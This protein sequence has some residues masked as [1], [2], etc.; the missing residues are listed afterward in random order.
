MAFGFQRERGATARGYVNVSNENFPV[1]FR[2]SRR[3]YDKFVEHQ[4]ARKRRPRIFDLTDALAQTQRQLRDVEKEL[5]ELRRRLSLESRAELRA[6]GRVGV[7]RQREMKRQERETIRILERED[8]T[9][10][11]Q[12]RYHAALTAYREDQRAR[13]RVLTYR[14]AQ[15]DPAFLEA[16][17]LIKQKPTPANELARRRAFQTLGGGSAF[18]E[19]Y[20]RR[21]GQR[22]TRVHRSGAGDRMRRAN[23]G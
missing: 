22:V 2:L 23:K 8:R 17:R 6:Q 12:R 9:A 5:A 3:Q 7:T 19:V 16:L 18:K 20:E 11:G 14:Q 13:G 1:G 15:N 10:K 21:Y 4:G